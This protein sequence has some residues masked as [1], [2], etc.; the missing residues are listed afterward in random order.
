[1]AL[2]SVDPVE[3]VNCWTLRKLLQLTEYL[4]RP[5]NPALW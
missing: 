1:M 4:R 3:V 5:L 2:L